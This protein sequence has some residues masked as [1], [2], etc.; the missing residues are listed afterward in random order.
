MRAQIRAMKTL[1]VSSIGWKTPELKTLGNEQF[2]LLQ[3]Y[4]IKYDATILE[5]VPKAGKPKQWPYTLDFAYKGDCT[6]PECPTDKFP[7]IWELPVNSLQDYKKMFEC[8][9]ID[10]CMFS[11]PSQESTEDFLWDNFLENYNSNKAPFGI[12]LRQVWFSH[13]AYAQN[14]RGLVDFI[15]KILNINDV[16]IVSASDVITWMENPVPT[17]DITNAYPWNCA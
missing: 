10:G 4:G 11:P 17:A 3:K 13:P 9:Y 1:N 6:V 8:A 14:L 16:Y 7:G 15:S 5:S 12:H 2:K